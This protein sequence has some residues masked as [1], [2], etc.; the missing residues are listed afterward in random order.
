[1]NVKH[2]LAVYFDASRVL[3]PRYIDYFMRGDNLGFQLLYDTEVS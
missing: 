3:L 1:M 2:Q